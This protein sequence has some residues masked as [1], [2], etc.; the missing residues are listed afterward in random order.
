M[1]E[2]NVG[3]EGVVVGETRISNVEGDIGRLSYRGEDIETLTHWPFVR[4]VALVLFGNEPSAKQ[5][6]AV[7]EFLIEN[8]ELESHELEILR[9]LPR[10]LHPMLVLQTMVQALI[11]KTKSS[12]DVPGNLEQ[13]LDGLVI[14]AKLP[15]IIA[16]WFNLQTRNTTVAYCKELS[17][18]GNF[19]KQFTQSEVSEQHIHILDVTQILQME[20]GFNAG[21][22]TGR[23]AASTQAPVA[24]VIGASFGALSGKLHGGADQAAVEMALKIGA[25]DKAAEYVTE[26]IAN[27]QKI[28]GMGHREY[29]TIDPRAKILKPLAAE[30][31]S[32]GDAKVLLDTLIAVEDSCREIFAEKGKDIWANVEFYKGAVFQALGIPPRFFTSIFALARVYGYIAHFL[33]FNQNPRLIRPKA[34]YSGQ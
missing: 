31:C 27:K 17:F 34:L 1:T 16:N 14:A 15:T 11:T 5:D 25:A 30:L 21:T 24:S 29:K 33:E 22:F 9:Q 6:S 26:A 32:S 3:L 18:H 23:V 4:V 8:G 12:F 28:M 13:A 20:H 7:E 19:L 2:I 10:D